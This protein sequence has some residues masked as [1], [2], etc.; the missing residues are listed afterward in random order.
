M[1]N[2]IKKPEKRESTQEEKQGEL[3]LK[4]EFEPAIPLPVR[5]V[6]R[7]IPFEEQKRILPAERRKNREK[8]LPT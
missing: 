4:K 5:V 8:S 2:Q 1:K 6:A 7:D 3:I